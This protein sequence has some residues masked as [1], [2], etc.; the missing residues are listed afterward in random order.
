MT[1]SFGFSLL[2]RD[3]YYNGGNAA[4]SKAASER[5]QTIFFSAGNGQVNAF[6]APNATL[7]SSQE[8]PDWMVTVGAIDPDNEGSYIGHGKPV[9]IASI[10]SGYP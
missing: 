6:A 1:N 10:G 9:D 8:R 7:P 3:R 4:L 5:G 2:L